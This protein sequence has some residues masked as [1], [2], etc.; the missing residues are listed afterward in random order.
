MFALTVRI[1]PAS[2]MALKADLTKSLPDVKSS[3]RVEAL[4]RGFGFLTYAA[5][6][7]AVAGEQV[8]LAAA[9]GTSFSRYLSAHGF[10]SSPIPFYYASARVALQAVLDKTPKLCVL[11]IGAGEPRRK[12]DGQFESAREH[13]ARFLENRKEFMNPF[14]VE[15]FLRGL[16]FLA[17]VQPTKTIRSGNDSYRLKHIAENY[18]CTYPEGMPLGPHYVSN[19]A[20]IA[21]AIHT[22]FRH[23]TYVDARGWDMRNADFNMSKAVIDDLDC[24]IR[25]NDAMAESRRWL[26]ARRKQKR[27]VSLSELRS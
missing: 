6:R 25:P 18:R 3:H 13:H 9:T 20:M 16:A 5:M 17:R 15:E 21:A 7:A 11:G 8:V 24:E 22:G 14:V 2:L 23:K 10:D 26:E 27:K 1:T 12:P 4:A 19:G